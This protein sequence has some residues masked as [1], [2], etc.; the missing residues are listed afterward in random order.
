MRKQLEQINKWSDAVILYVP[1]ERVK[2]FSGAL[3]QVNKLMQERLSLACKAVPDCRPRE[4]LL[5][6]PEFIEQLNGRVQER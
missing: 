1:N 6:F 5:E 3:Q 4:Q 2:V